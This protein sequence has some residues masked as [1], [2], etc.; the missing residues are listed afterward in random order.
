[1]LKC[2]C[3]NNVFLIITSEKK[4]KLHKNEKNEQKHSLFCRKNRYKFKSILKRIA[5]KDVLT[6]SAIST[7]STII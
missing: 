2:D 5:F 6:S 7:D 4:K 1:M 3:K